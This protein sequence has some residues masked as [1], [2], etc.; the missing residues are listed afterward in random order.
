[1]ELVGQS[2]ILKIRICNLQAQIGGIQSGASICSS[3]WDL[4]SNF[5]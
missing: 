1:M 2:K 4:G 3:H 5:H